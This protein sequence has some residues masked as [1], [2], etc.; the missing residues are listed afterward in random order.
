MQDPSAQHDDSAD[1]VD[2][3]L[4]REVAAA[5]QRAVGGVDDRVHHLGGDVALDRLQNGLVVA[6]DSTIASATQTKIER[7]ALNFGLCCNR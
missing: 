1:G 7:N 4:R 6:H 3:P 2:H 5:K